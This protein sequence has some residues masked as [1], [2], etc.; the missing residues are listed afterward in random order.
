MARQMS[1]QGKWKL[2]PASYWRPVQINISKEEQSGNIMFYGFP[3]ADEKGQEIIGQK[4]YSVNSSDYAAY[5][6]PTAINPLNV[7]HVSQ[8]Y[9]LALATLDVDS[10]EKDGDGKPI[11][12]SF[13]NGS[14]EV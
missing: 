12:V 6:S 9:L 10:G 8:A 3:N 14:I 7:N 11:M 2:F 5:F 13:F 4:S 1:F